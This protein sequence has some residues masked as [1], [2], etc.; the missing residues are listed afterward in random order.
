MNLDH[1][2]KYECDSMRL[3]INEFEKQVDEYNSRNHHYISELDAHDHGEYRPP[4]YVANYKAILTNSLLIEAQ[5]LLDFFLPII[6]GHISKSQ[7][8]CI[9]PF[10]KSWKKGNVLCWT[11][12]VLKAELGLSYDFSRGSYSK[13]KEFYE[14]RNDQIHNGGYVSSAENRSLL[15]GKNGIK[16]CEYTEL[17]VVEFSYCRDVI[18]Q[19]EE[20][21][22]QIYGEKNK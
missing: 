6:V 2:Y 19:I 10:D 15:N 12:T 11:K 14:F 7:Q 5:T 22:D 3:L 18:N 17:Y 21:F 4:K 13:L 8:K 1:R 20:F 9:S 16:V